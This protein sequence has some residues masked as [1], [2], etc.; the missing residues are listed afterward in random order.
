M[1]VL[2]TPVHYTIELTPHCNNRCTGCGNVDFAG[3]SPLPISKWR[4]IFSA[5]RPHA[6]HVRISG[7]E[8]TL[9]PEFDAIVDILAEEDISFTLFSN[10]R[11]PDPEKMVR[12]LAEMSQCKGVLISLHGH[13]AD[14]HDAFAA[15]PGAFSETVANISLAI[16]NG[17]F[18][19]TNTIIT[20]Q[21]FGHL[22]EIIGLSKR[23]GARHA[24]FSRY[25]SVKNSNPSPSNDQLRH[26]IETIESARE[27]GASV[28]YS[29]CI[30][31]CFAQSASRGCLSGITYCVID[32]RG[33]MRPCTHVPIT[34]GN[35][36]EKPVQ[37]IWNGPEMRAWRDLIPAE[38][39]QD[40]ALLSKCRGGCRAMG[41]LSGRDQDPLMHGA[42]ADIPEGPS[43][44]LVLY[45]G[46]IPKG[47]FTVREESFGYVLL[48]GSHIIPVSRASK[49]VLDMFENKATLKEIKEKFGNEAAAFVGHLFQE[50]FVE[51]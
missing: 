28:E 16:E 17:L 9:H 1:L 44:P 40:C 50:G 30:P 15:I 4:V 24:I 12:K 39:L 43:K 27:E 42:I 25:V 22:S 36:L 8:P 49:P 2:S 5:I 47:R 35:V 38:C 21:N 41:I 33:N 51:L 11:W 20:R 10:G 37:A 19:A 18:V 3:D 45:E 23:L 26:A 29:V 48:N 7:G 6:A 13:G 46:S 34:C 14:I 32:P 31:Q